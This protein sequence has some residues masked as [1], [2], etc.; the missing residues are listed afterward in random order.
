MNKANWYPIMMI[1][2]LSPLEIGS[3]HCFILATCNIKVTIDMHRPIKAH[4]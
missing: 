4:L 2:T 1:R 3:D